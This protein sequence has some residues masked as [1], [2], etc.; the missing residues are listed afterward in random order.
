M[1][2][3]I[4]MLFAFLLL[5]TASSAQTP[6]CG[7]VDIDGPSQVNSGTPLVFK[8]RTTTIHTTKPEF[9]WKLS[10]GA[11]M[12]GQGTNEITVDTAGLGGQVVVATV[13]LPG[14]PAGCNA[15]ASKTVEIRPEPPTSCAFDSYGD[16]NFEDEK[17]RLDNIAVQLDNQTLSSAYILMSAGQVTFRNEA[18]ERLNRA[19][20]YLVDVRGRD[21]NRI[22]TVDCGFTQELRTQLWVVPLGAAPPFCRDFTNILPS[23]VRFTKQRRKTSKKRR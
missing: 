16:I 9:K 2:R 6:A 20:S 17:A 23:E 5:T 13:E 18:E 8:V 4:Q 1:C 19:K 21:R 3:L 10:A 11:I 12:T 15:S 22:V 7:I 14:T